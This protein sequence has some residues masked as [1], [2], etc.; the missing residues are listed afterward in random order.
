MLTDD[1]IVAN[2]LRIIDLLKQTKREGIH[3]FIRYIE[4]STLMPNQWKPTQLGKFIILITKKKS[5]QRQELK[6]QTT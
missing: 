6:Y 2:K 4:N 5:T 3:E 1:D